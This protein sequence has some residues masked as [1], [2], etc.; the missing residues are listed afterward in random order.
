MTLTPKSIQIIG[1]IGADET[2]GDSKK[3]RIVTRFAHRSMMLA[4][5]ARLQRNEENDNKKKLFLG[6]NYVFEGTG[7][8][9]K[10][11]TF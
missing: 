3:S 4:S 7:S 10:S 11:L 1:Y 8:K 9:V 6:A 2:L 5:V